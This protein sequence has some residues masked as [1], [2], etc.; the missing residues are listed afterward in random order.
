M[1]KNHVFN[2]RV[3]AILILGILGLGTS[4]IAQ[5]QSTSPQ[6]QKAIDLTYNVQFDEAERVLNAYIASNPQ[7]PRGYM[8]RA[9]SRD[10]K[11]KVQGLGKKTNEIILED[12]KTAVKYAFLQWDK[13]QKNT[14]KMVNL[15]NAYM[16]LANKWLN[17]D[18]KTRAGLEL[19]KCQKHMEEAVRRDPNRYDAYL[20]MG[21]FNFYAGNLPSGLKFLASL[22]GIS[23]NES[24]GLSQLQKAAT[25]PNL[26]QA[27]ALVVLSY[28]YGSTKHDY[29]N[30]KKYLDQLLAKYPA[31][32]YLRFLKGE[33]AMSAKQYDAARTELNSYFSFCANKPET[34]CPKRTLFMANH[35]MAN[36]YLKQQNYA[37][38]KPYAEKMIQYDQGEYPE[39]SIRAPYYLG[40]AYKATGDKKKA[41]AEFKKVEAKQSDNPRIWELAEKELQ[42]LK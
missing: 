16:L 29:P 7:D 39:I 32:P 36:S 11:R 10:W 42:S 5:A 41:V 1:V 25:N 21:I 24:L 40:M 14:D 22:L 12:Y 31:N 28:A 26:L 2:F 34:L 6:L 8:F 27:D 30:A 38:A 15:G 23:G 4:A 35:Y 17:L 33:F 3:I 9:T 37:P 20:A 18:K 13:D 19:K